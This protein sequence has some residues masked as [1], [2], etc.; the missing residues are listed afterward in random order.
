MALTKV[1]G[2]ILDPG[3]SIAGVVTATAF[4]GPFRGGSSSDIIAGIGTFTELDVNGN[5]DISGN[6][7]VQGDTTTLNTTLRTVEL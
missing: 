2:D 5:V 6:L 3:L 7:T 4:D 1:A